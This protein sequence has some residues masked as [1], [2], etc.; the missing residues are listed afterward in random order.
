MLKSPSQIDRAARPAEGDATCSCLN[1]ASGEATSGSSVMGGGSDGWRQRN[2]GRGGVGG[3]RNRGHGCRGSTRAHDEG[4]QHGLSLPLLL[5]LP[6][7]V[8]HGRL[9]QQLHCGATR[10]RFTA[11]CLWSSSDLGAGSIECEGDRLVLEGSD[12]GEVRRSGDEQVGQAGGDDWWEMGDRG[13][14]S[15]RGE[16]GCIGRRRASRDIGWLRSQNGRTELRQATLRA[17]ISSKDSY[18]GLH[19]CITD[20]HC[21]STQV[22]LNL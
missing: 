18:A 4:V 12:G 20:V 6:G 19:M 8:H 22:D 14:V 3:G 21:V 10:A 5:H 15:V 2:R 9:G 16:I 13:R 11:L 1:S 17:L 7:A